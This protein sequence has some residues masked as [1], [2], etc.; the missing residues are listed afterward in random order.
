MDQPK[1]RRTLTLSVP[2][3]LVALPMLFHYVPS[4]RSSVEAAPRTVAETPASPSHYAFL[5][6]EPGSTVPVRWS[7]CQP[8]HYVINPAGAPSN[9]VGIVKSAVADAQAASGLRFTFDGLSDRTPL[10]HNGTSLNDLPEHAPV[11]IAW[12]TSSGDSD[13]KGDTAGI[14]EGTDW[15]I[16]G[17]EYYRSGGV[18]LDA[19]AF[20]G[21]AGAP[22]GQQ[23]ER[24]I[25]LHELGHM[26]GLGHVKDASQIMYPSTSGQIDYGSGDRNG[27]AILGHGPC[28]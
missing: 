8:I 6:L 16:D 18:T 14:G 17:Y 21:L 24:S 9:G 26:L 25:V 15:S 19:D 1:R 11:L 7:P 4:L 12:D 3:L 20:R 27:L 5:N 22:V 23:Q 13:L 2:A 28:G 10:W